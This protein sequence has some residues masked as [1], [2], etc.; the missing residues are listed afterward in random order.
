MKTRG[1]KWY[2]KM[3]AVAARLYDN[4]T[5]VKG[6]NKS[7]EEIADFIGTRFKE[8][9][10]LDAG[11]GPGRLIVEISKKNEGL[12]LF[13][14]DI[15]E[16]MLAV[17]RKNIRS[18]KKVNLQ[19]GNITKT[20]YHDDFFDCI[21]S[22][23]SFYNWDRPV[24]ALNEIYRILK[25]G[26]KAYIF[27]TYKDYDRKALKP[28]LAENLRDYSFFRKKISSFFLRKQ[29]NMTYSVPEYEAIIKQSKFCK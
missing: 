20:G 26:S 24:E 18:I 19:Q 17:A 29:L 2:I 5:S 28:R 14:L 16:S 11:T 6:I 10:L 22:T 9:K 15:S 23:G 12:D 4:L 21:V 27:D 1:E 7:F 8:G 3:P 13:G 25:P